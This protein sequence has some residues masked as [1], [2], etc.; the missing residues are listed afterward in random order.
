MTP[1]PGLPYDHAFSFQRNDKSGTQLTLAANIGVAGNLWKGQTQI[2]G[3]TTT[4]GSTS[5]IIKS[6]T[7]SLPAGTDPSKAIGIAASGDVDGLRSQLKVLAFQP[8]GEKCGY[9]P[10]SDS[11]TSF[12]KANVRDGHYLPA[13]PVHFYAHAPGGSVAN[14]DVQKVLDALTGRGDAGFDLIH[15]EEK[16]GVVPDCAMRVSRT[17]D[18]GALASYMPPQSCE[19]KWL[20]EAGGTLPDS[21]KSCDTAKGDDDCKGTA[22]PKCH[23]GFCEVK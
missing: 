17:E 13:G 7:T 3:T 4:I 18:G 8:K 14:A 1:D 6:L 23:Y 10:D 11:S 9:T 16:A 22:A 21:C 19:C 5:D 2:P 12:D 15:V 20:A